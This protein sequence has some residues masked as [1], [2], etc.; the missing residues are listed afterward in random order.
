[1]K[2]KAWIKRGN[3]EEMKGERGE[4]K[5]RITREERLSELKEGKLRKEKRS[6]TREE[7]GWGEK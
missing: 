1:M 5:K 7:K 4:E 3:E 2:G 6:M